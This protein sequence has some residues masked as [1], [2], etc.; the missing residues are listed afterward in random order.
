MSR[1]DPVAA[2]FV[3]TESPF[4]KVTVHEAAEHE[5]QSLFEESLSENPSFQSPVTGMTPS[6]IKVVLLVT[7]LT[8]PRISKLR[9]LNV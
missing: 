8:R 4:A 9:D 5:Q 7:V 2:S 1:I 6:P 3:V